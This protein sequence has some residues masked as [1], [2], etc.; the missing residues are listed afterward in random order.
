MNAQS[1]GKKFLQ[2][3]TKTQQ[4]HLLFVG[5]S[6]KLQVRLKEFEASSHWKVF[7]FKVAPSDQTPWGTEPVRPEE[8]MRFRTAEVILIKGTFLIVKHW[9]WGVHWRTHKFWLPSP[10][11]F[12]F[13]AQVCKIHICDMRSAVNALIDRKSCA[14]IQFFRII[15]PRHIPRWWEDGKNL[16]QFLQLWQWT[17][18]RTKQGQ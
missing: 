18:F 13:A 10:F 9:F 12:F 17:H 5:P 8:W 4:K 6:S 15:R 2:D 3:K 11:F 16:L 7:F 1:P 14:Y